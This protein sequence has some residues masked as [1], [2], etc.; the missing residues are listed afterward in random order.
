MPIIVSASF[1][2]C[3]IRSYVSSVASQVVTDISN[4][5][6]ASVLGSPSKPQ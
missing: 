2:Y 5:G 4:K 6:Y 3:E 1:S